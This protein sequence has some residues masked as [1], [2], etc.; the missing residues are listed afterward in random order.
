MRW[1]WRCGLVVMSLSSHA[2][3][4]HL[5]P[6]ARPFDRS[7]TLNAHRLTIHF[8]NDDGGP[9]RPLLVYTTGDGGWARKDLALYEQIV[10]WGFPTAGFSAPQYLRHLQ[11]Q[12]TTT[13]GRVGRDY[14]RI[15]EFAMTQIHM[16]PGTPIILVGVS[17]GAGLEVVA[18]GQPRLRDR[19]G[20]VIA[21]ALTKEEEN[22][23]W[24]GRR[25]PLVL[26]PGK[27][28]M[29]QVYDYLPLL[30]TVP[31][32]VVQSTRDGFLPADAAARLFG[33]DTTTRRFRAID[34]WNHNFSGA[35]R[36]MYDAARASLRW[37][38]ELIYPEDTR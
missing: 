19:L 8:A 15:I 9:R 17:R 37:I 10:S 21:I 35:R 32:A 30:G 38:D 12:S 36:E 20:G 22:V 13:P 26:R 6:S 29:L 34:A 5:P 4:A 28:E 25:V 31:V 2:C 7:L 1:L 16:E 11:G 18:A 3:A 14:A 23:R 33:P 27:P 24:F